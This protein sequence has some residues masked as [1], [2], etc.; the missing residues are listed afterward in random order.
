MSYIESYNIVESQILI[1]LLKSN[2]KTPF[3]RNILI[4]FAN[5]IGLINY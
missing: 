5:N 3:H 4:F 2:N 1:T